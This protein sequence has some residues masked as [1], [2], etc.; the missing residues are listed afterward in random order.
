[1]IASLLIVKY[2]KYPILY[3]K[4]IDN[5]MIRKTEMDLPK[6]ATWNDFITI[7]N[8]TKEKAFSQEKATIIL[9]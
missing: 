4:G 1:M 7:A 2:T 8:V 6:S 9:N 5:K 3:K